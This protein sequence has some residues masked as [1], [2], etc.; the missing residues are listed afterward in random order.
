MVTTD[1]TVRWAMRQ[2]CFSLA[3]VFALFSL[4]PRAGAQLGGKPEKSSFPSVHTGKR[5]FNAASG[6]PGSRAFQ[7]PWS[8]LQ[9]KASQLAS[10]RCIASRP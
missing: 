4:H 7:K 8:R 2:L 9:F 3:L 1:E 5:A 6:W 10:P